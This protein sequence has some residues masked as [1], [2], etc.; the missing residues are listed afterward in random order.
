MLIYIILLKKYNGLEKM[1]SIKL[2][3]VWDNASTH[4]GNKAKEFYLKNEIEGIE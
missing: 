1:G 2:V 4:A 3:L